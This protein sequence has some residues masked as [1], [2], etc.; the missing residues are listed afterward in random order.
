M[1]GG[2]A[3][4]EPG[5]R[6]SRHREPGVWGREV[7]SRLV[8]AAGGVRGPRH[9]STPRGV[10]AEVVALAG[11]GV[12]S[13]GPSW[14]LGW[15]VVVGHVVGGM[16]AGGGGVLVGVV[17]LRGAPVRTTNTENKNK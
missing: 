1:A 14:I 5:A 16:G 4:R 2:H 8:L 10:V 13:V 12:R 17:G 11:R 6:A 7:R 15:L 3:P 9:G